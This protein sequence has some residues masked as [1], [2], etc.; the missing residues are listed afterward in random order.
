VVL[1]LE[2]FEHLGHARPV[3]H[4]LELSFWA[5]FATEIVIR[6][7]AHRRRP[8]DFFRHG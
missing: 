8:Q 4:W 5:T 7:L 3:L 2:T 6:V 1:G